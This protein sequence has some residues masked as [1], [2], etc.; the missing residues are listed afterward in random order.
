MGHNSSYIAHTPDENGVIPYLGKEHAVWSDLMASQLPLLTGRACQEYIY[1]LQ[2]LSM[3]SDKIPQCVELSKPLRDCTGWRV[4]PVPA[5]ISFDKFFAMLADR[6]FPA[7]SFIRSREEFEYLKEPDIFHE[8]FGH[9]PLLTNSDVADFTA[10]IGRLGTKLPSHYHAGLARLYW[11]TVEFG[12]IKTGNGI[13]AYGA[14]I[15]SSKSEL[16]YAIESDYPARTPFNLLE[17]ARTKYRIDQL[18]P[19][20]FVI[21]SFG[22]FTRLSDGEIVDAIDEA[23]SVGMIPIVDT[24]E[25]IWPPKAA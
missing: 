8:L 21:N 14:G 15:V 1:G 19:K 18:Q 23:K 16:Q 4:E 6:C 5:L 12:L 17:V 2:Q 10:R 11:M 9:T 25:D 7:A 20:Y 24:P 22:D 13:R 3:S